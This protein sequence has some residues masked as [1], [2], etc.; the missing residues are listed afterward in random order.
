MAE[1]VQTDTMLFTMIEYLLAWAVFELR[2]QQRFTDCLR[3]VYMSM[4][5][6]LSQYAF[7]TIAVSCMCYL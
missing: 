3:A 2:N 4:T 5:T 7:R 1:T 6:S